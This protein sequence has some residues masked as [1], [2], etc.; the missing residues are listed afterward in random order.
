LSA[1]LLS[2]HGHRDEQDDRYDVAMRFP[3]ASGE[4]RGAIIAHWRRLQVA[5]RWRYLNRRRYAIAQR[6]SAA[7]RARRR[8]AHHDRG[9][10]APADN[11]LRDSFAIQLAANTFISVQRSGTT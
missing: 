10:T 1:A 9:S 7:S 11:G 3:P 6:C 8:R 4:R 2:R 5:G